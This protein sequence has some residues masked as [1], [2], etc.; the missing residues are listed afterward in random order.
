MSEGPPPNFDGSIVLASV[1]FAYPTR[2]E[3]PILKS[4]NLTIKVRFLNISAP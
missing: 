2:V 3:R 4:V 1:D